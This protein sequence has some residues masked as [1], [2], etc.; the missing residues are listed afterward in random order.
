MRV[1]YVCGRNRLG[2][3]TTCGGHECGQLQVVKTCGVVRRCAGAEQ[4]ARRLECLI[5]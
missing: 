3:E 2:I 4:I 5:R 1:A